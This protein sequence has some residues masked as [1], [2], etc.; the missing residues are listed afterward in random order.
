MDSEA[1]ENHPKNDPRNDSERVTG[2]PMGLS[3]A[4]TSSLNSRVC[5][6]TCNQDRWSFFMPGEGYTFYMSVR[7]V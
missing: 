4:Q 3:H 7:E 1:R 6:V 5:S 2:Q